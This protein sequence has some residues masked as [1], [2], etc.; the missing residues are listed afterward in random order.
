[1]RRVG[2]GLSPFIP[3]SEFPGKGKVETPRRNII[4]APVVHLDIGFLMVTMVVNKL[5]CIPIY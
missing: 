5:K 2:L 3:N 4:L 1:M